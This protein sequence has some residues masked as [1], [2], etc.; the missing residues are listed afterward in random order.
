MFQKIKNLFSNIGSKIKSGYNLGKKIIGKIYN[1][2][3]PI[4]QPKP[5]SLYEKLDNEGQISAIFSKQSYLT[6]NERMKTYKGYN[7]DDELSGN[8]TAVYYNPE[9]KK[10]YISHRGTKLSDIDDLKSD[11][12]I[13]LG[14]FDENSDRM[15]LAIEKTNNVISK[16]GNNITHSAHSL[17]GRVSNNLAK[18]Y[19]HR[20]ITFSLGSSFSDV[21]VD[22]EC[23]KNNPPSYCNNII[24]Y[25]TKS[26]VISLLNSNNPNTITLDNNNT[27]AIEAHSLENFLP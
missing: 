13:L 22:D 17:G 1:W 6:P 20:A 5:K 19:N 25:R 11:K 14:E 23:L 18:M 9:L 15:K 3:K 7:Y 27:S 12:E 2:F 10:S 21:N 16:Y 26:D 24:N 8:K 4:E